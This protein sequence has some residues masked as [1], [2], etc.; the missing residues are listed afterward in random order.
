MAKI[1]FKP[2]WEESHSAD[3]KEFLANYTGQEQAVDF[4]EYVKWLY[5]AQQ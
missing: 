2:K 3:A 1:G 5:G 4:D